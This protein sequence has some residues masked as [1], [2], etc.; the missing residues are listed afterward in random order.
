VPDVARLRHDRCLDRLKVN[1]PKPTIDNLVR[2]SSPGQELVL[3]QP[4]LRTGRWR[5]PWTSLVRKRSVQWERLLDKDG[6]MRR[7]AVVPVF[8]FD[9]LPR[10]VRAVVYRRVRSTV[11][12]H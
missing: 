1:R 11:S 8:G 5:A 4:L 9:R 7:E 6:R 2:G 12:E 3:V 10:G